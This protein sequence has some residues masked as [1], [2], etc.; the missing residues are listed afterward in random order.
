MPEGYNKRKWRLRPVFG[1]KAAAD[2]GYLLKVNCRGCRRTRYFL[3]ADLAE[4]YDDHEVDDITFTCPKC[5]TNRR[6]VVT[7]YTP[8]LGDWGSLE[9]RRPLPVSMVKW[10]TVKLG[11]DPK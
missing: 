11:D 5:G 1:L 7:L 6:V 4:Q 10:R 2:R 8:Q 9:V 3:P